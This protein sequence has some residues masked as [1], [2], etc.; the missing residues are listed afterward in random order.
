MSVVPAISPYRSQ[1]IHLYRQILK[2]GRSWT[3]ASNK[4]EDTVAEREFIATEAKTLFRNNQD[5]T[6]PKAIADC[7]HEAQAR[8]DLAVHYK[9][10]YPRP[11]NV[12]PNS[13][14]RRKGKEQGSLQERMKKQSVP[15]YI[16]SKVDHKR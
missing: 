1:V 6:D 10:P 12:P 3:A 2:L 4:R 14:A 7:V 11:L 5:L 9:T 16:K 8:L 13:L 15:V